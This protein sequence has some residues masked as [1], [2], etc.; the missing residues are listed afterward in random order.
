MYLVAS[1]KEKKT[2]AIKTYEIPRKLM[3]PDL[4]VDNLRYNPR[5]RKLDIEKSIPKIE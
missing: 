5:T 1:K 2:S 3:I 4:F